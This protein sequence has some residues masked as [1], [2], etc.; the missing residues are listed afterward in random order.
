LLAGAGL[1]GADGA[2]VIAVD[3]GTGK[4]IWV[5]QIDPFPSTMVTSSP[6]VY[7][8]VVYVGV[9]SAGENSASVAGTPCCVSRGSMVALDVQRLFLKLLPDALAFPSAAIQNG[10]DSLLASVVGKGDVAQARPITTGPTTDGRTLI[11][12]GLTDGDYV[13]VS[14]HYKLRQNAKVTVTLA[15]P[16]ADKQALAR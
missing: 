8:D 9:A 7:N 14:G 2:K 1:L 4:K 16:A 13:V 11:T 5:T 15:Q 3:A 6:V 10:P 12:S